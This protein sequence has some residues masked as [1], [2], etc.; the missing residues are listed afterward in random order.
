VKWV[1]KK[2]SVVNSS[3]H[4]VSGSFI[5]AKYVCPVT[6]CVRSVVDVDDGSGIDLRV[7]KFC[8]LGDMLNT[9]GGADATVITRRRSG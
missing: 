1:Y 2:C 4:D 7:D 9:D 5:C 8:Y 3:L 6:E